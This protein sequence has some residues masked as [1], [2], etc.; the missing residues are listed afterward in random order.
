ML[1]V[2]NDLNDGFSFF[3]FKVYIYCFTHND[4]TDH[5]KK[6]SKRQST[7]SPVRI[8]RKKVR[9]RRNRQVEGFMVIW[10]FW[11]FLEVGSMCGEALSCTHAV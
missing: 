10:S 2:L 11:N 1:D 5:A 8:G 4:K 9:C 6:E 7:P 3:F